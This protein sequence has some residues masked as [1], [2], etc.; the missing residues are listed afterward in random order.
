MKDFKQIPSLTEQGQDS[1]AEKELQSIYQGLQ[2]DPRNG[3]LYRRLAQIKETQGNYRQAQFSYE[4][5]IYY[6]KAE[7][8][9][10]LSS[11][12]EEFL[13]RVGGPFGKVSIVIL[14]YNQLDYTK[15]CV[16]SIRNSTPGGTYEI[17]IV[18]NL[19]TDGTR[20]WLQEQTDIRYILNEENAGF[21]AGCNQGASL[22]EEE[23]DIFFLNNDT[24][25]LQNS[26]YNLRMALHEKEE[27]GAVG[28]VS[29]KA[30]SYQVIPQEFSSPEE[31]ADF[32]A[33]NNAYHPERHDRCLKLTGFAMMMRRKTWKDVAG[34]DERYGIGNFEDDDICLKMLA[35]GLCLL[36]CRD[37][38]IYH[39]GSVSFQGEEKE[40]PGLHDG[41]MRKNRV[42]FQKKW[43]MNWSYFS[44]GRTN[45][46]DR[47]ER[48][49]EDAFSLLE[50][51]C[52]A[53]ASLLEVKNRYPN[54]EVYG[55]EINETV[56]GF[57]PHDLHV[58][59]GDME[60][61]KNYFNTTYDY[62]LLADVLEHIH[63]PKD[64]LIAMKEWL[65]PGGKFIIS[66]PNIM[67]ISVIMPLLHG[68]FEY[69]DAGILDRTHLKFF[70]FTEIQKMI[71]ECGLRLENVE[72]IVKPVTK[73]EARYIDRLC[74][75]DPKIP[76]QE[77]LVYEYYLTAG[78]CEKE[79]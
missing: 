58:I 29:N 7:E 78:I 30:R 15:L 14:T 48:Q 59:Q 19:S 34:F 74:R 37:S 77:L 53:G 61:K 27:N 32:A 21:A 44:T 66:L 2:Q 5:A 60:E 57:A 25:V 40:H 3:E 63:D 68:R 70:T 65:N 11:S 18:D 33:A 79:V 31:Y 52:A 55:F 64:V 10:A 24:I 67:N 51:G 28:A 20:E 36:V 43:K 38:F 4:N 50:G 73:Q 9:E 75:M 12:Y 47:I 17:I 35:G 76:R 49:R 22:A 1:E 62:I 26:V 54:A 23:N 69:V 6:S 39:F 42:L 72:G 41:L 45:L 16:E 8:Y 56:A 13:E 46:I 71:R